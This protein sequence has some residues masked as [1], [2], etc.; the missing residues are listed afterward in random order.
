TQRSV[1]YNGVKAQSGDLF[2]ICDSSDK[3]VLM[4]KMPQSMNSA[5]MFFSS[6]SI[7]SGESYNVYSGGS[8]SGNTENWNG[9]YLDG[10]YSEGTKLGS[11]TSSSLT[12]TVGQGGNNGGGP[13]HGPGWWN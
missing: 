13:G 8:V 9:L 3:P 4:F 2:V 5:S 1:I 11:F 7:K 12:T 6:S 10:S